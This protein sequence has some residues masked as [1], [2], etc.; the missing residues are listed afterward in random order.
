MVLPS[1]IC[2]RLAQARDGFAMDFPMISKHR[3]LN[4]I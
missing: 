4:I 1:A 2:A 3:R